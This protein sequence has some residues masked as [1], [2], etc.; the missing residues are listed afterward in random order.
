MGAGEALWV[1][2]HMSEQGVESLLDLLGQ[3]GLYLHHPEN[4][5]IWVIEG[6]GSRRRVPLSFV[7]S[8]WVGPRR[9]TMQLWL[10]QDTDVVIEVEP[11][12]VRVWF[13]LD[14]F[15][16]QQLTQAVGALT[17]C[18]CAV[19]ETRLLVVDRDLEDRDEAWMAALCSGS[20]E[21]VDPDLLVLV[22]SG[23][24]TVRVGDRSWLRRR[25]VDVEGIRSSLRLGFST[26]C[27]PVARRIQSRFPSVVCEEADDATPEF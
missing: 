8:E 13:A 11:G 25:A 10:D 23:G 1:F 24:R 6:R 27:R 16:T 4:G 5:H 22:Q 26:R 19:D 14:G 3:R 21:A 9:L 15:L 20:S 17:L 2:E 12:G 7:V 18:A